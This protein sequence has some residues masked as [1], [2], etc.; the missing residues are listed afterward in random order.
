MYVMPSNLGSPFA[1][2]AIPLSPPI[3]TQRQ[4]G[5]GP[6]VSAP[7]DEEVD[8]AA[9]DVEEDHPIEHEAQHIKELEE[10]PRPQPLA[11]ETVE[12]GGGAVQP[13]HNHGN[14][15]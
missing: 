4:R 7:P 11:A 5:T 14:H 3:N 12:V 1:V 10:G 9:A 8:N 6:P 13:V 15:T 2:T